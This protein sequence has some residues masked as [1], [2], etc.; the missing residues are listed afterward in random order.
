MP[1]RY[2]DYYETLGVPR[3]ATQEEIRK[4]YRKL[5]RKYHPDVNPGDK[6]AEEKFK[7]LQEAYTVLSDPEKRKHYDQLGSGWKA[8]ADFTPPPGW[9]NVRVEYGN[10]ED[11]GD[12]FGGGGFS[13]FFRSIFGGFGPQAQRA[14]RDFSMRG[15]DVEAQIELTLEEAHRGT[16]ARLTIPLAQPCSACKGT[17]RQ[18]QRPCPVCHGIGT[19]QGS[20]T[21]TA[22]IAPGARDGSVVRLAGQGQPGTGNAPAGDL[23]LQVRIKPHPLFSIL[24]PDHLQL[25]LPVAPWEAAL[26]ATVPVPTLDGP[27]EMKIP[28]G[29]QAGKRFRLRGQGLKR[30][31]G[32]RG[33][34]Y[35]R[36]KIVIPPTLTPR[37]KELFQQ[38]A[39]TSRF[40]PRDLLPGGGR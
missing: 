30:R 14:G 22:K 3:T 2:K 37:E 25:D 40:N 4:A 31:S 16:Q 1:V 38:L 26:G 15:S 20:K 27:V 11:L 35:A 8:G 21:I 39:E 18:R 7:D 23:Y 33:D 13:D 29:T 24:K 5:A 17:G 10:W 6:T 36:I 12:L 28:P 32:G 19:T 9:E 34:L